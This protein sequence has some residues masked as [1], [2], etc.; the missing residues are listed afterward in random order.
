[1]KVDNVDYSAIPV[2]VEPII[3]RFSTSD[4]VADIIRHRIMTGALPCG[5]SINEKDIC[6]ELG[7]SRTPLRQALFELQGEGLVDIVHFH[8]ARVFMLSPE[9]IGELGGFRRILEVE[10]FKDALQVN[11]PSTLHHLQ[12]TVSQ[13]K[14][15]VEQE[16]GEQFAQIDTRFHESIIEN[17]QNRFLVNS[18]K[19]VGLRLA[20]LRNI[21]RSKGSEGI[22]DSYLEHS[23]ILNLALN[24][25]DFESINA[26]VAHINSGTGLYRRKIHEIGGVNNGIAIKGM[27]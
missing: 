20:V 11:R 12:T 27:R 14:E 15:I 13:M 17:C 2:Q 5:M 1:M 8:G 24:G 6:T 7:I 25:Q 4:R 19:A 18:Y 3:E 22:M 9:E 26:L 10:A 23:N 16:D 21:V